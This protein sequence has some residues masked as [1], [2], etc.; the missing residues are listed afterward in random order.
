M[1]VCHGVCLTDM[2]CAVALGWQT[3]VLICGAATP[4]HPI[5]ARLRKDHHS[6]EPSVA[7][8]RSEGTHER[9]QDKVNHRGGSME[10]NK[11]TTEENIPG[12]YEGQ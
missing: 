5:I 2:D 4:P 12:R 10:E 7:N 3:H 9:A 1:H 8:K 6:R 11:W